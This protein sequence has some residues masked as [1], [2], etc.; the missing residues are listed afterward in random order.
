MESTASVLRLNIFNI[1]LVNVV[2]TTLHTLF[3]PSLPLPR[4]PPFVTPLVIQVK[5]IAHT[6]PETREAL[7]AAGVRI[8]GV[9]ELAVLVATSAVELNLK[10]VPS[11]SGAGGSEMV[12]PSGAFRPLAPWQGTV[13]TLGA[14]KRK[15]DPKVRRRCREEARGGCS[16]C[17]G[18]C[19]VSRSVCV[20]VCV[21]C[22]TW[23]IG[24]GNQP[25]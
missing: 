5:R 23:V 17:S 25:L 14:T 7:E 12:F 13:A 16:L 21:L 11:S 1:A 10:V 19:M 9:E 15:K 2:S 22:T 4:R 3:L 20:C 8:V 6:R 24:Y 18:A